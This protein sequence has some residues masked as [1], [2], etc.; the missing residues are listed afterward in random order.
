V[1]IWADVEV[2]GGANQWETMYSVIEPDGTPG[3]ATRIEGVSMLTFLGC[4]KVA[5]AANGDFCMIMQQKPDQATPVSAQVFCLD[6]EGVPKQKPP[7]LSETQPGGSGRQWGQHSIVGFGNG[8]LA[9]YFDAALVEDPVTQEMVYPIIGASLDAGGMTENPLI[10]TVSTAAGDYIGNGFSPDGTS[11]FVS[12]GARE[13]AVERYMFERYE[14]YAAGATQ[15]D[16]PASTQGQ[17]EFGGQL[18]GHSSG[19]FVA[20]WSGFPTQTECDLYYRKFSSAGVGESEPIMLEEQ[21]TLECG[22]GAA[23]VVASNGNA[24]FVW[25]LK[26]YTEPGGLDIQARVVAGLFDAAD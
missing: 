13:G 8:F 7:A 23:G 3:P 12:Y 11:F 21:P 15:G 16:Q 24:M 20:L 17:D 2:V 1:V 26:T 5:A 6:S 25:D 9:F 10:L 4:P 18:V 19:E 14:S 22:Q